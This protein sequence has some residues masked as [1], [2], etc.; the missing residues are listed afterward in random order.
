MEATK[1]TTTPGSE[2]YTLTE[3]AI[4]LIWAMPLIVMW[5][6]IFRLAYGWFIAPV[7]TSLPAELSL[8]AAIGL[9][10]FRTILMEGGG[11]GKKEK[12][13]AWTIVNGIVINSVRIGMLALAHVLIG[14]VP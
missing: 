13:V 12:S 10:V 14:H 5:G 8:R 3:V 4:L 11:S 7:F 6:V 2:T 1:K 9:G